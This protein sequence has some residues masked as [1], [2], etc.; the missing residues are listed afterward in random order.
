MIFDWDAME[1]LASV[2]SHYS[3]AFS[4]ALDM[5]RASVASDCEVADRAHTLIFSLVESNKQIEW[6]SA[7]ADQFMI[8]REDIPPTLPALLPMI[9]EHFEIDDHHPLINVA[10]AA[11]ILGETVHDNAFHNTHHFR[12]VL[13]ITI[14]LCALWND[15]AND[16]DDR[17]FAAD[18]LLLVTA[19]AIHDFTH[20]G[21]TNIRDGKHTPSYLEKRAVLEASPFLKAAGISDSDL[22]L[23]EHLVIATDV[24]VDENGQSP[25]K[26]VQ[27]YARKHMNGAIT[28]DETVSPYQKNPKLCLMALILTEA[29]IAPSTGLSYDFSKILTRLVAAENNGLTPTAKTLYGFIMAISKDRYTSPATRHLMMESLTKISMEASLDSENQVSYG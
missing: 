8:W 23:V 16:A 20:D 19:A 12:E 4:V 13:L 7:L 3:P 28:S 1:K 24:S 15:I 29:D 6:G 9:C 11:C 17:F 5:C 18:I 22:A 25:A 10:L 26:S 14:R 2:D 27:T 21:K